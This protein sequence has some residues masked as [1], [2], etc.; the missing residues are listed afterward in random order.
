MTPGEMVYRLDQERRRV[1]DRRRAWSWDRFGAFAGGLGGLPGFDP[2]AATPALLEQA[3]RRHA[4]AVAGRVRLLGQAWPVL[5]AAWWTGDSWTL[6]PVSGSHWDGAGTPASAAYRNAGGRGDVKFVWELNRLQFLVPAA[7]WASRHGPEEARA[8]FDML[9]GWMARNPPFDGINWTSG[10]EAAS[11]VASVLAMWSCIGRWA[12]ADD[13]ARMRGFLHA[14]TF[15]IHRYPSLYSSANNHR[16]AELAACFIAAVA[17]PDLPGAAEFLKGRAFLEAEAAL[18]VHPD[19][20]G[21]EQSPTYTAYSVEWFVLAGLAA[22]AAGAPFSDAY[23]DRLAKAAEHLAWLMDDDLGHPRIGDDDEGRVL[24]AGDESHYVASVVALASRWLGTAARRPQGEALRDIICVRPNACE[25]PRLEGVRTFAE[26]GYTIAR[27]PTAQGTALCVFDHGPLGFLSIAAHGH[28]DALAVWL[29]L[30]HEPVL[31]DAG[32]YLY[33]AGGA[34]RDRF[35]GTLAHNTL[36]LGGADQSDIAGPFLWSRHARTRVLS[37]S[38][39]EV[40]AATSAYVE[41]YGL[42]HERTVGFAA[43]RITVEDALNGRSPRGGVA[44]SAGF[45]LA[46]GVSA[47]VDGGVAARL[48]TPGGRSLI[49]TSEEGGPWETVEGLYSPSFNRKT[50]VHRLR[51]SGNLR[52]GHE[53]R[54]CRVRIDLSGARRSSDR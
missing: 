46:P 14:H 24:T 47:S 38:A 6:D 45:T 49:L 30:G 13:E 4:E 7:L 2:A 21:A 42:T 20:V 28:A 39:E 8:V 48:T 36:A 11:R 25:G 41:R 33:H 54:V 10:I 53:G 17:A 27:S 9:A 22:D 18:Q 40:R 15:R 12:E 34:W 52:P 26:G 29:H 35:R 32:A 3:G 50:P 19:G 16:V 23:R 51:L 43:G 1:R 44:W 37:A 5:P 31:V